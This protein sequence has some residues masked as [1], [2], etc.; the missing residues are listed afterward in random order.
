MH[1]SAPHESF[2]AITTSLDHKIVMKMRNLGSIL[3]LKYRVIGANRHFK[4]HLMDLIWES[5]GVRVLYPV[6]K[7]VP[8]VWG[9]RET[10]EPFT[11]QNLALVCI[12][13]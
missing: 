12:L 9:D 11:A 3:C 5:L 4:G 13:G 8:K 7:I 6:T 2:W 10:R 1:L